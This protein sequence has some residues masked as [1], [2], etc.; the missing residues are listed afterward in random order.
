MTQHPRH[1]V[2]GL[3]VDGALRDP[4]QNSDRNPAPLGTRGRRKAEPAMTQ[5]PRHGVTGLQHGMAGLQGD[6]TRSKIVAIPWPTPIH[7]VASPSVAS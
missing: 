5:H 7:I 3:H 2:T 4:D 6:Y 1:G